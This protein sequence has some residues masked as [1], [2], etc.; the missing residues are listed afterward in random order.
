M[1]TP[2]D[3]SIA[4]I[5]M[6]DPARIAE[7]RTRVISD[8]S[9]FRNALLEW[10]PQRIRDS[11]KEIA[12]AQTDVTLRLPKEK[13]AA[14]KASIDDIIAAL[15]VEIE[16][17]F[18]PLKIVDTREVSSGQIASLLD[19]RVD[20]GI[21]RLLFMLTPVLEKAGYKKDHLFFEKERAGTGLLERR[22]ELPGDLLNILRDIVDTLIELKTD[23]AK[24]GVLDRKKARKLAEDMWENT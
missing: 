17:E 5:R 16:T 15:E 10:L 21:R 14:L 13:M 18:T 9:E 12:I 24:M 6:P 11:A 8:L 2:Q 23:E 7:R 4:D 3:L 22:V 19:K 20:E 1:K